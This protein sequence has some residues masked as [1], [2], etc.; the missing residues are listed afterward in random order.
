MKMP[1]TVSLEKICILIG[2]EPEKNEDPRDTSNQQGKSI[3][4]ISLMA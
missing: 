3:N 4:Q 2:I 1:K